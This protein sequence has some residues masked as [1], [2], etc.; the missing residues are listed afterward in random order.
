LSYVGGVHSERQ[1]G[2]E[3]QNSQ[4][5]YGTSPV[6]RQN[7]VHKLKMGFAGMKRADGLE[8]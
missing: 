7:V 2:K 5:N 3:Y 8:N 6:T 4:T 1:L